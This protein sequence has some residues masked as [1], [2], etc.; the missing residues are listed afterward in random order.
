M[1]KGSS[2]ACAKA[3]SQTPPADLNKILKEGARTSKHAN[4]VLD[5]VKAER[6]AEIKEHSVRVVL[7][8]SAENTSK[9]EEKKEEELAKK[10]RTKYFK[11]SDRS[12]AGRSC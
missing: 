5:K 12:S 9:A 3:L 4:K 2:K 10:K 11:V 8:T 7:Y 6:E 1:K